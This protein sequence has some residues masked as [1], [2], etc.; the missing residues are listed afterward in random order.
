MISFE[1][2]PCPALLLQKD[3]TILKANE[4]V[5]NLLGNSNLAD[6]LV[7]LA[8]L[9]TPDELKALQESLLPLKTGEKRNHTLTLHGSG[10]ETLSARIGLSLLPDQKVLL[11]LTDCKQK[12]DTVS[13][14]NSLRILEEQYQHNPAGILLV[15]DKMEMLSYNRQFLQMWNIPPHVRQNRDDN[16]S[17]QTVLSQVKNPD[18]FLSKVQDLYQTPEQSSTDE[19][20]LK[21]GR[22]FY[23][24]SYPIFTEKT[25]LGRVW[26]FLDITPLK[27]AQRKIIRQQKFQRAVLENIQDG[28]VAC[29]TEGMLTIFNRASRGIHGCDPVH[30]PV[31][32]WGRHYQL[33]HTDGVTPLRTDEIPLVKAFKGEQVRN[34]EM[35]VL[36][37]GGKKR[38]LRASGQAMY[39]NEGNKLGAVISLHD[40]TDLKQAKEKLQHLAYHDALTD[41]P[42][43]RMFHDLLEQN[44]R[45]ARRNLEKTAVLFLDLDN[46][47]RINDRHGHVAGDRLL[48]ALATTLRVHLR[49][50]DILCRWGGDEFLIAL[51][52]MTSTDMA[53]KVAEK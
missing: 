49:N 11:L 42:N 52:E 39:D 44:I 51:P 9:C 36:S 47:K 20:E 18:T 1:H 33:Y 5:C 30:I 45:R 2:L 15:T 29:N 38:E 25:Y 53:R 19:V 23:R 27:A 10:R 7:S 40:I 46:F 13:E 32:E 37:T 34:Q 14:Q 4:A 22:T 21:D 17:L 8:T 28:I 50:S 43:R 31:E 16:E 41:L 26:Y 3:F 35:L 24:H 12:Q 48:V 6:G